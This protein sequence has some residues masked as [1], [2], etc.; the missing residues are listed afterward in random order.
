MAETCKHTNTDTYDA[1]G[2]T[3]TYCEDCGVVIK[4]D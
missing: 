1:N 4:V 3:H 2:K